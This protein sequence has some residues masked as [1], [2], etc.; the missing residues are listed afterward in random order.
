MIMDNGRQIPRCGNLDFGECSGENSGIDGIDG[1]G[2]G[3]TVSGDDDTGFTSVSD[4]GCYSG[5][6]DGGG[7][8]CVGGSRC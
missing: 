5:L 4:G 1:R 6:D 7:R 8:V 3:G 2:D